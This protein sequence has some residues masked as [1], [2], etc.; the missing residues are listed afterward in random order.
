MALRAVPSWAWCTHTPHAHAFYTQRWLNAGRHT[1]TPYAPQAHPCQEWYMQNARPTAHCLP[2]QSADQAYNTAPLAQASGPCNSSDLQRT[3]PRPCLATHKA[4]AVHAAPSRP[5]V[6]P[7]ESPAGAKRCTQDLH[8]WPHA[9]QPTGEQQAGHA[10]AQAMRD[11]LPLT[12]PHAHRGALPHSDVHH[13]R[14]CHVPARTSAVPGMTQQRMSRD[15][16]RPGLSVPQAIK[17]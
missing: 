3:R 9:Q 14:R 13:T 1:Q 16:G 17:D 10:S 6:E 15:R 4:A 7:V 8:T 2:R 11:P 5:W 12:N